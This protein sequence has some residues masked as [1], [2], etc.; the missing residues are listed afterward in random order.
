MPLRLKMPPAQPGD[1]VVDKWGKPVMDKDGQPLTWPAPGFDLESVRP[2]LGLDQPKVLDE[3]TGG[4]FTR[5]KPFKKRVREVHKSG[6]AARRTRNEEFYPWVLEDFETSQ[7]W[8]SAREPLP[9]SLKMLEQYYYAEKERREHGTDT[10]PR[11][12]KS[13]AT[14]SAAHG[15]SSSHAPWIG[16]L[17]G[18]SDENSTSH[19]V[20]FVFDERNAGGFK[21]V[22]IRRQYKF[23]QLQKH[24]LSSEQVEE[25][26]A[27]QQ[28]SSETDRWMMRYRYQ[29]GAGTGAVASAGPS[30]AGAA[31]AR[32]PM[33]SLP[34]QPSM[35]GWQ[36]SARLVAVQGESQHGR[37][38]DDDL[39]GAMPKQ[40]TTYDELDFEEEFADDEERIGMNDEAEEAEAKELDERLKREMV[41]DHVDDMAIKQEPDDDA[42]YDAVA[43]NRRSGAADPLYGSAATYDRHDDAMLTGSGRQM[44]KIMKAL[45]RREGLDMYDSDEEAKNPYA[46]D[47]S[48]DNEDLDVLH[49]ERAILA[50][51]EEKARAERMAAAAAAAAATA[52]PTSAPPSGTHTPDPDASLKRKNELLRPGPDE[53]KKKLRTDSRASSPGAGGTPGRASSPPRPLSPLESEIAHL[54][55]NGVV[56][57]TSDLVQHFRARLKQDATLKEQLSAAVKRIAYMD[58]KDNKLKL[59]EAYAMDGGASS[60]RGGRPGS[61]A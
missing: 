24:A 58:K 56:A 16:Q 52:T 49:P 33:L 34:G 61:T 37:D 38:D 23:M 3:E 14:S 54:L 18:D 12:P 53:P 4:G 55:S 15:P 30:R 50:A 35:L 32:M 51:R 29:T 20:L 6:N 10:K 19:H 27:R 21:V 41:A 5:A 48:D 44:R 47:E 31:A 59:K 17:E 8:E 28:R 13:E 40:E 11:M 1:V 7:E 43:V 57:S 60:P 39:F 22:P 9:N 36:S 2:Y 46:S 45:S 25:E 26:F 42:A